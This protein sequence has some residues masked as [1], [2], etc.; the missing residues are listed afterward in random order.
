MTPVPWA[1][2][3][4]Q[5]PSELLTC[6][7]ALF[8]VPARPK[9]PTDSRV[10]VGAVLARDPC[11]GGSWSGRPPFQICF[12]GNVYPEES[13]ADKSARRHAAHLLWDWVGVVQGRCAW[14]REC[15]PG[16][17]DTPALCT[18]SWWRAFLSRPWATVHGGRGSSWHPSLWVVLRVVS[19]HEA[20]CKCTL[21]HWSLI[22]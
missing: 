19:S 15:G 18:C 21:A 16:S 5:G 9:S 20:L 8:R 14:G 7:G 12:L 22:C 1:G 10:S 11:L 4:P 6:C 3:S 17:R 13:W 2:P